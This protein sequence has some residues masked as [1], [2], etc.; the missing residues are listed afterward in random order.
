MRKIS[1]FLV[2]VLFLIYS[3]SAYA[4]PEVVQSKFAQI[5]LVEWNRLD[6]PDNR[7]DTAEE[8]LAEVDNYVIQIAQFLKKE[9]WLEH[10]SEKRI[11]FKY[12]ETGPSHVAN[13]YYA[14]K[15]LVLE[16][17]Y[18]VSFKRDLAPIAHEITHLITPFYSAHSLRE[19]LACMMQDRF[20]KN[21]CAFNYGAPVHR[22]AKQFLLPEYKMILDVIGKPGVPDLDIYNDINFRAGY[23]LLSH[24]FSKFLVETYEMDNF[25]KLYE[26]SE[27]LSSYQDVTGKS[28][29]EL[30]NDW[31]QHLNQQPD[32]GVPYKVFI[33]KFGKSTE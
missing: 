32:F 30:K 3:S 12:A 28:L 23:Y 5:A 18:N 1:A 33:K 24:S 25:M 15:S 19:G 27:L 13:G 26:T 20:G 9:N 22:L 6:S 11:N 17:Y 10:Y 31:I 2:L 8:F 21:D 16:I 29:A 4:A 14:Y 7:F